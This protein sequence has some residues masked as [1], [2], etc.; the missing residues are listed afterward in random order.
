MHFST[1]RRIIKELT[2]IKEI[3]VPGGRRSEI[4]STR[5]TRKRR[6]GRGRT[7]AREEKKTTKG[8]TQAKT[9]QKTIEKRVHKMSLVKLSAIQKNFQT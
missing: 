8:V 1:L 3:T 2:N 4:E 7:L 5:R 9:L 6:R